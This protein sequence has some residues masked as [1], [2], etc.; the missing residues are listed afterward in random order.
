[1]DLTV[2]LVEGFS[3][4]IGFGWQANLNNV[5]VRRGAAAQ[6]RPD[7]QSLAAAL[8]DQCK[9][10]LPEFILQLVCDGRLRFERCDAGA[11]GYVS[12]KPGRSGVG[13]GFEAGIKRSNGATPTWR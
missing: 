12:L 4:R 7:A 3:R 9:V 8:A 11:T 1:L 13:L 2:N 6:T 5:D 10:S